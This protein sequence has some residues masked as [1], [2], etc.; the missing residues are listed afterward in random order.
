LSRIS[1]CNQLLQLVWG[2][3]VLGE[4]EN[5][6]KAIEIMEK[7]I[8]IVVSPAPTVDQKVIAVTATPVRN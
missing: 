8:K 2:F 3:G 5:R 6:K 4:R 1:H 7:K